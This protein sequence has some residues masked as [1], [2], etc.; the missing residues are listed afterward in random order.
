ML[1]IQEEPA[2]STPHVSKQTAGFVLGGDAELKFR[3]G[4]CGQ[5]YMN[6]SMYTHLLTAKGLGRLRDAGDDGSH[7]KR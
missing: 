7:D 3:L 5:R 2:H 4:L 6:K 1:W